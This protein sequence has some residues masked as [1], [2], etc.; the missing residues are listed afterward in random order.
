LYSYTVSTY[1]KGVLNEG[2]T[3]SI[4]PMELFD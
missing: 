3:F 1:F 4:Q 2:N